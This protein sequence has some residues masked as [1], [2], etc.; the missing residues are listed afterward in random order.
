MAVV[1]TARGTLALSLGALLLAVLA[2]ATSAGAAAKPPSG[3]V[4][5]ARGVT[6]YSDRA[7]WLHLPARV[8][9]QVDVFYLY[10]TEF[11]RAGPDAPVV[12]AVTDAGMRSGA[13]GAYSRQAT[14]FQTFANIYAPFYRQADASVVLPLPM[15]QKTALLD[16][17]P[18]PDATAAFAYYIEH[19]NHGRP[20]IL[21]GHSQG[22]QVMSILLATYLKQHRSVYRRMIAAY[23]PGFSFIPAYFKANPHLK[24]GTGPGDTG[25]ILS[26]NTEAPTISVTNPVLTPGGAV[27]NPITWS[28]KETYVPASKNL[29]SIQLTST[30]RPVTNADGSIK[31][32]RNLADAQVDTAKGVL[33]CS[34]VNPAD[35]QADGIYHGYDFPFYFFDVRTNAQLR[36]RNFMATWRR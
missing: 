23:L 26:W 3:D 20:F 36:V 11:H 6:D 8:T 5:A 30:G 35:Y 27:I 12:S 14:A 24:F 34:T 17:G 7:N 19:Y 18:A 29:G 1:A 28:R 33:V 31:R 25:V 4:P 10:P 32:V 2:P 15:D 16:T 21:A 9:K 13:Y 22:A